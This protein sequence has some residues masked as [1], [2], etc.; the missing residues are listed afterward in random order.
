MP[1]IHPEF[2]SPKLRQ[3]V[4]K[5]VLQKQ[6]NVKTYVNHRRG[7]RIPKFQPGNVAQGRNSCK[8]GPEYL[9]PF[10]IHSQID[11]YTF[12]LENG[13]CWNASNVVKYHAHP[14][15]FENISEGSNSSDYSSLD[16]SFSLSLP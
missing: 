14:C 9:R 5:R 15:Y 12:Q 8:S 4:Q 3:E 10:K 7:T 11:R 1:P 16:D 13:K 2:A 6:E